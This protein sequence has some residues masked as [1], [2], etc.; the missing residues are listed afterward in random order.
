MAGDLKLKP[1][2]SLMHSGAMHRGR[3]GPFNTFSIFFFKK[4]FFRLKLVRKLK[5]YAW[6]IIS[7]SKSLKKDQKMLKKATNLV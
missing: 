3:K 5:Y 1:L 4:G 2:V 6:I 7:G